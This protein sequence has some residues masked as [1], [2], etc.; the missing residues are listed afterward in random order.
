MPRRL[1]RHFVESQPLGS[2]AYPYLSERQ[3]TLA[4]DRGEKLTIGDARDFLAGAGYENELDTI[5]TTGRRQA[6]LARA[7]SAFDATVSAWIDGRKRDERFAWVLPN[8][9]LTSVLDGR[10][11]LTLAHRLAAVPVGKRILDIESSCMWLPY[12]ALEATNELRHLRS[13]DHALISIMISRGCRRLG[14]EASARPWRPRFSLRVAALPISWLFQF[15]PTPR[16]SSILDRL[17]QGGLA[18]IGHLVVFHPDAWSLLRT[19]PSEQWRALH[20]TLRRTA[21]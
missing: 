16:G 18:N 8:R 5:F 7:V 6:Q 13:G 19:T 15:D 12:V 3:R 20:R 4:I 17:A 11:T 9:L 21:G 2:L 1:P 10:I 14:I